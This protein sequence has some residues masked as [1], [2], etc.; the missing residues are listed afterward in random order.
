[1]CG[2][3]AILNNENTFS[4]S[5]LETEFEKGESRGPESST[6]NV[7]S[8]KITLGFHRLAING[9][10]PE[11]DQP[12]Q[13]DR[14]TLICNGEIYNYR[15]LYKIMG[16]T[17]KTDSDCEVIIHLYNRYGIVQTLRM[18]DGVF[19]FVLCDFNKHEQPV[20]IARD[21]FGVRAL[22]WMEYFIDRSNHERFV[23]GFASELKCLS[24][25]YNKNCE[26]SDNVISTP[27][28]TSNTCDQFP[29][30]TYSKLCLPNQAIGDYQID[31]ENR[32]YH[33][34]PFSYPLDSKT[35]E[36]VLAGIYE[37]LCAAVHKRVTTTEREVACLLSGG[38]DS[39]LITGLVCK[40]SAMETTK[41]K[42]FSI[43]LSGSDDLKYAKEVADFLGT[44]HH[45]IMVTEDEM[46][47]AIPEVIEKI[48]SYDTTT[49]RAS[50]GN[51][52][53]SKY[54]RKECDAKVIFNGDGSDEVTGGYM[55]FH[56]ATDDAAF[57]QE[58]RRL[59]T[60]IHSFDVLRSD[61]SISGN[62]L[63][64]R[65]PFLDRAFVQYYLTL[66]LSMRNHSAH[67][68]C[69]K[70]L[71]RKAFSGKGV[72]PDSVLWRTKEAF[73]DGVSGDRKSWFEI[74]DDKIIETYGDKYDSDSTVEY[75]KP[76]TREQR[77]YRQV[78]DGLFPNIA[79]V[80]P[81]FWMPRFIE[82]SDSSAR[83]LDIY[84]KKNRIDESVETQISHL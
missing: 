35:E 28:I 67:E 51:Y 81:Y 1:M 15:E 46:F 38:L 45:E 9:L 48:E 84:K 66:P 83:T 24:T 76:T 72:I 5:E 80:L 49:I 56:A 68:Q 18:L 32:S 23:Y 14:V 54:I 10:N 62:G 17:P 75:N 42:T 27:K 12:I 4:K 52:M 43:G 16:V 21:P 19:A 74:I 41:V 60:D 20:Y 55:Y 57:D 53:V 77:Y 58:C 31:V 33:D 63:E 79:A 73:S 82:A 25:L 2:I 59:L 6:F 22:Y 30:G 40:Y 7:L 44:D 37:H 47:N 61:K 36:N 64:A 3:F 13:I 70:Y 34:L 11:S 78:F 8:R 39:S 71:L 29:P 26:L 69:E 65:T 50:V